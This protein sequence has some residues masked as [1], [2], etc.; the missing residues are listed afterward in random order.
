MIELHLSQWTAGGDIEMTSKIGNVSRLKAAD[1]E[2]LTLSIDIGGTHIKASVLDAAGAMVAERMEVDT[3]TPATPENV[4]QAIETTTEQ[5]PKFSRISAGFPGVVKSGRVLTAPNLGTA[6][7]QGF[8][9]ASTLAHRYGA[10]TRVMNDAAVQGLGVVEGHGLECVLTLGT[11]VGCAL[12]RNRR[13]VVQLELGQHRARGKKTYDQ[14]LGN[15]AL[16]TKGKA[17]W[18]KRLRKALDQVQILINYDQLY[19]GGGNAR[20]VELDL[21]DNVKIVSNTAG[22]TGGVRL[23]DPDMEEHFAPSR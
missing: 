12:Y 16:Q 23:W 5:L 19:I 20:K 15:A 7:W 13:L 2:P 4:L 22:I 1:A 10:P 11:G 6:A 17:K 3:P 14:Y 8:D 9:L 18:N 21:P